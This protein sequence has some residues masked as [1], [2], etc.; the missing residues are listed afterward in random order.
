MKVN[1]E[2]FQGSETVLCGSEVIDT[3][4]QEMENVQRKTEPP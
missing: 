4:C 2:K 3:F 1:T